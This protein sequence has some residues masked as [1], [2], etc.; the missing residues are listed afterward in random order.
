MELRSEALQIA[1]GALH[2]VAVLVLPDVVAFDLVLVTH[3]F[4]T[5]RPH[6]GVAK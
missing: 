3:V 2:T 4:G 1:P 6:A 5:K